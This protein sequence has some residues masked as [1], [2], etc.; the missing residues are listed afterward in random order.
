MLTVLGFSA[1][2]Q[3]VMNRFQ[4]LLAISICATTSGTVGWRVVSEAGA[5]VYSAS[6]L[7]AAELPG[8]GFI[9]NEHSTDV[10]PTIRVYASV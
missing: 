8:R 1:R 2:S 9:Q 4:T 7:A 10:E 3:N 5:S 6:E